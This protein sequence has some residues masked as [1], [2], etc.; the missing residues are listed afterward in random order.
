VD[1]LNPF[2]HEE[3]KMKTLVLDPAAVRAAL[4]P[5]D[6]PRVAV[7]CIAITGEIIVNSLDDGWCRYVQPQGCTNREWSLALRAAAHA[8]YH[9]YSVALSIWQN[10]ADATDPAVPRRMPTKHVRHAVKVVEEPV[11]CNRCGMAVVTEE[12]KPFCS[13]NCKNVSLA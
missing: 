5:N 12:Y 1:E 4:D 2:L 7:F 9:Q 11:T 13:V 3:Y 6:N 8:L 10:F